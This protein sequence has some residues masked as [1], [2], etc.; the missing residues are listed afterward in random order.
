MAKAFVRT[1]KRDYARV[2]AVPDAQT[3]L[4]LLPVGLAHY[5]EVHPHK[6]L[7]YRSPREFMTARSAQ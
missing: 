1:I 2:S 5:D 3:V 4:Q 7:G 6:A